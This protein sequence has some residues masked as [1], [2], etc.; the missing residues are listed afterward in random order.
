MYLW[1]QTKIFLEDEERQ[2]MEYNKYFESII[3][4]PPFPPTTLFYFVI[5]LVYYLNLHMQLTFLKISIFQ[6]HCLNIREKH[7]PSYKKAGI[8]FSA[9]ITFWEL[10]TCMYLDV[11]YDVVTFS[12]ELKTWFKSYC[13]NFVTFLPFLWLLIF[14]INSVIVLKLGPL[15][16]NSI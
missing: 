4:P 16:L 13:H 8:P 12:L 1:F 9:L 7:R 5:L 11:P 10:Y 3:P 6:V 2:R 15:W 14:M